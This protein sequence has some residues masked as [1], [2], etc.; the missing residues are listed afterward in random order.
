MT[1]SPPPC[2]WYAGI[3]PPPI[4]SWLV[5]D[6]SLAMPESVLIV[7]DEDSVRRTFQEWL[8]SSGLALRILAVADAESALR[9]AN[10][11]PIDL[12]IL[13]WNLGSGS[14]GLQL[15]E[16]LVEFQPD[17]VAI[18]V[19]GFAHQATPLDA[20]RMGVR[21]YLDKNHDLNRETFLSAVKKQLDRIRPAKAHR[22]LHR[23]L[24][25]FREAVTRTLPIIQAAAALHEPVPLTDAVKSLLR[26][27]GRVLRTPQGVL[28]TRH[29]ADD[30]R[31]T[32]AIYDAH[33]QRL[34]VPAIP[35]RLC[36]AGAVLSRGEPC[37]WNDFD[38][39][40]LGAVQLFPFEIGIRSVLAAPM[41]VSPNTQAV[42]E[43]FDPPGGFTEADRSLVASVTEIG[44][45]LLRLSLADRQVHRLLH[46][47]LTAA[48]DSTAQVADSL[49]PEPTQTASDAAWQRLRAGLDA[50]SQVVIDADSTLELI[51]AIRQLAQ[52]HGP[53]AVDHITGQVQQLQKLLD[54]YTGA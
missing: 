1:A 30:G 4:G 25:A 12:A 46:D 24:S 40:T 42:L 34:E 6:W 41:L 17:I 7:D 13:D 27:L 43:F 33:G 47:A 21:D 48:L 35:F 36:L 18:L 23:S 26:F 2:T 11:Q 38:P 37:L 3:F 45:E 16:D 32:I 29:I 22:Q 51:E 54:Q 52:R 53:A 39:A 50:D 9:A 5:W 44:G 49:S 31:E 14:D 8:A 15:L 28:F 19:T 20:L 10:E